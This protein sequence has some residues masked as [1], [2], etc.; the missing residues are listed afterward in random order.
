MAVEV[1]SVKKSDEKRER[2]RETLQM[3]L[4]P[5]G[6]GGRGGLGW[7]RPGMFGRGGVGWGLIVDAKSIRAL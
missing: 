1:G 3:R 7:I 2:E 6:V 4:S 5:N